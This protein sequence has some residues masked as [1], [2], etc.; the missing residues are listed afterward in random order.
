MRPPFVLVDPVAAVPPYGMANPF[1]AEFTYTTAAIEGHNGW[2]CCPSC[3]GNDA[4]RATKTSLN[5]YHSLQYTTDILALDPLQVQMLSLMD[6]S[7]QV[8]NKFMGFA[9]GF[10]DGQSILDSPY[11]TSGTA[12]AHADVAG[13]GVDVTLHRLL[14]H[15]LMHN[16]LVQR[17]LTM[18]EQQHPHSGMVILSSA[19]VEGIVRQAR[20]RGGAIADMAHDYVGQLFCSVSTLLPT[21][22]R[23]ARQIYKAPLMQ[24][25]QLCQ[26]GTAFVG[27]LPVHA[28]RVLD[29]AA[30]ITLETAMFPFLFPFGQ[31]SFDNAMKLSVYLRQKTSQLFSLFTLY[32]PY[33]I[34]MY[35][36]Q[37]AAVILQA[38][39]EA[40]FDKDIHDYQR[41]HPGCSVAE[42]MVHVAKHTIPSDVKGSPAWHK[43][44]LAN[45]LCL[46]QHHGMPHIF[47]TLT[48]DEVS[49]SRW[50]PEITHLEALLQRFNSSFT[51]RD[52]PVENAVLF[53]RRVAQF[54][55]D[56]ILGKKG[57]KLGRVMHHVVRYEVQGRGSLHAHIVLWLHPDD[58]Q[59]VSSEITACVPAE[60][61]PSTRQFLP[62]GDPKTK[63][64]LDL[65]L[66]KQIHKCT[67]E[68]CCANKQRRC[69][70]GFPFPPHMSRTP[71]YNP[72]TKRWEYYRPG[73]QH[74]NCVPYHPD[75]LML[76]GAHMNVQ[77]IT[78][79]AWSFYVLKYALK[80]EP[81]GRLRIDADAARRLGIQGLSHTELQ[82]ISAMVIS[83]VVSPCEAAL[84]L[85]GID[86]VNMPAVLYIASTPPD[87]RTRMVTGRGSRA[88][89]APVDLY[90]SRPRSL[91]KVK[92]TNY[93]Q[94]YTTNSSE[95]ATVKDGNKSVRLECMGRDTYG[96]YVHRLPPQHHAVVRFTDF[97]PANHMEA[98]F[99][100]ILLQNVCF[101]SEHELLSAE[102]TERSYFVECQL[103]GLVTCQEDVEEHLY[104]YSTRH[105]LEQVEHQR[106]LN[107]IQQKHPKANLDMHTPVT[108]KPVP[109]Q[110]G[111]GEATPGQRAAAS[112][113]ATLVDEFG[114]L[115]SATLTPEQ[116]HVFDALMA[117]EGGLHVLSGAPGAGKTFLTRYIA[118]QLTLKGQRVALFA[119]TGA[120][121][122]RL[123]RFATTVHTG[124]GI[125]TGGGVLRHIRE[126]DPLF[127]ALTD[128]DAIIIDEF[129]MLSSHNLNNIMF[130]L[131]MVAAYL[132]MTIG[133][134]LASRRVVL[135]GDHCQLPT[136]CYCRISDDAGICWGC[137]ITTSH[138]YNTATEYHMPS[139]YRAAGD[140]GL[141]GF[142]NL[143]R[144][145]QPSQ[146]E[147]DA[148]LG[149]CYIDP[150][151]VEA[152]IDRLGPA[153]VTI[154]CSHRE[155][156]GHYNSML[157]R[158]QFSQQQ[159][160]RVEKHNYNAH[161]PQWDEWDKLAAA[162]DTLP[163]VA[164]GA[165]VM[166][167]SNIN[168]ERGG[169]NGA[170]GTVHS[171]QRA[172]DGLIKTITVCLDTGSLLPVQRTAMLVKYHNGQKYRQ[173]TFSLQLCYSVTGHKAQGCTIQKHALLHVRDASW[174]PGLAYVMV[175]RVQHRNKLS[176]VGA[177]SAEQFHPV[178][179]RAVQPLDARKAPT[180]QRRRRR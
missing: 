18:L 131:A 160:L 133:Q 94:Q 165:P 11:V 157:L 31:S 45:L 41:L 88:K 9:Q 50:D 38:A 29:S 108:D 66:R 71:A 49:E 144:T 44:Q 143:C 95:T 68:G 120:A 128:A 40:C 16:P 103:R 116:Q 169:V 70:Y 12:T 150:S 126:S 153:N 178:P 104:L 25:G 140:P 155:D 8:K 30:G 57:G 159:I 17:Y 67:K 14:A 97:H 82:L 106:L 122:A 167:T 64:L 7:V 152:H 81:A 166:I 15:N 83:N 136:V 149:Q 56:Y 158:K 24:V 90:C 164:I 162:S 163:E 4:L 39:R 91:K 65:V 92:F 3:F 86:I 73:E 146:A 75:V 21:L 137:H 117:A 139:S 78:N 23:T 148:A 46:V 101:R 63:Q 98:Y 151:T 84:H 37:Q 96:N 2:W 107:L 172:P 62:P 6:A 112:P 53:H 102:N 13:M 36:V 114:D 177:I 180:V 34:V 74:R 72:A 77:R 174:C 100:N 55:E 161:L 28:L 43:K 123:S 176:I 85:L 89:P 1:M 121:A 175:S 111:Q 69:Q 119:T 138:W 145:Q 118:L 93:F 115:A 142:L 58:V 125:P 48:A 76:W 110:D 42:A 60:W 141:V 27:T 168:L 124:F 35:Q 129:S 59:P 5:P 130:R 52:A 47:L 54:M 173:M 156:V 10:L 80:A 147:V 179:T 135:V 99:Y 19:V 134:L 87:M 79:S 51:W 154:L 33:I 171:I 22:H 170:M 113:T 20:Q 105:L 32:K 109:P 61:D 26:R 132:N 127:T